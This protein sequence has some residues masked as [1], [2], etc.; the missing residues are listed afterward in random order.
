MSQCRICLE[1]Q[2]E[3]ISPCLCNGTMKFVHREC[4][5][6]WRNQKKLS[7][8]YER[9]D[10]CHY[11]YQ[12]QDNE[13]TLGIFLAICAYLVVS[14]YIASIVKMYNPSMRMEYCMLVGFS[15]ISIAIGAIVFVLIFFA[16]L[17]NGQ[18]MF[19]DNSCWMCSPNVDIQGNLIFLFILGT[20]IS[21]MVLVSLVKHQSKEMVSN[22]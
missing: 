4:L 2:G 20:F 17:F 3:M 21:I 13:K 9:C 7:R 1:E 14:L 18:L 22:R 8:S 5:N 11:T 6:Q 15:C 19:L 16:A 10:Q 12:Y